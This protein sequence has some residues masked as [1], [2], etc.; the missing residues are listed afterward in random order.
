MAKVLYFIEKELYNS[1]LTKSDYFES[2]RN[3]FKTISNNK[4]EKNIAIAMS[5]KPGYNYGFKKLEIE[6]IYDIPEGYIVINESD[7]KKILDL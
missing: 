4:S 7:F 2:A 3:F 6:S 1:F 5:D